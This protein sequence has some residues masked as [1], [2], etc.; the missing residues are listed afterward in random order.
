MDRSPI[1]TEINSENS[2]ILKI[3]VQTMSKIWNLSRYYL[4]KT[5]LPTRMFIISTYNKTYERVP[6]KMDRCIGRR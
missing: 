4:S 6:T 1:T 2:L 3:R 5:F